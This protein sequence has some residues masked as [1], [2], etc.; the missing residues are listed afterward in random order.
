MH[1][2]CPFKVKSGFQFSF[3]AMEIYTSHSSGGIAELSRHA[4]EQ[5]PLIL[6]HKVGHKKGFLFEHRR[7]I[8]C[9]S[10]LIMRFSTGIVL[11][12]L[13]NQNASHTDHITEIVAGKWK[14]FA[15]MNVLVG[16]K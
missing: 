4:K 10:K 14:T 16:N 8:V 11:H 5:V 1:I 15:F 7:K 6:K 9:S 2:N 3:Y 13:P 12:V